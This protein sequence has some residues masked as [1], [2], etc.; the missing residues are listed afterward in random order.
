MVASGSQS[1]TARREKTSKAS[2]PWGP[3]GTMAR[4]MRYERWT[5]FGEGEGEREILRRIGMGGSDG[6]VERIRRRL[7]GWTDLGDDEEVRKIVGRVYR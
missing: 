3:N 6:A 7:E 4:N 5:D 1:T 2:A